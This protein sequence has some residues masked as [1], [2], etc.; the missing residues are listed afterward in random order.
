MS[1]QTASATIR[2][3]FLALI[4]RMI[5]LHDAVARDVGLSPSELQTLHVVSLADGPISPGEISQRTGLPRST[6]TRTLDG[7]ERR[8]Y[9][10][11]SS[12][13]VDQR[14]VVVTIDEANTAHVSERFDAYARA[15]KRADEHFDAAELELVARYW[16]TLT[17]AVDRELEPGREEEPG[18]VKGL[19]S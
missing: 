17:D 2:E 8:G 9:L 5:V 4:P 12:D 7:L 16:T 15:M 3:R 14:R 11:R 10:S 18:R 13:P 19:T 1:K 6:V